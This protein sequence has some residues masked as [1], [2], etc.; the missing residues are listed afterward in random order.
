MKEIN[1]NGDYESYFSHLK[2][3][4]FIGRIYKK[5]FTSQII[6]FCAR[7]FGKSILEVGS[8]TGSGVL[9][10]FPKHVSG[11]EINPA[12]VAY[13]RSRGLRVQLIDDDG[14]F[15][16]ANG[17]VDVCIL[18]NVLEHIDDPEFTLSECHRVTANHGGLVVV[19]PGIRGYGSDQ[20][21]KKFYAE[22]DLKNLDPR[23][24]F[25]RLFSIPFFIANKNISKSLRQYCLVATYARVNERR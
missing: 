9:G 7:R 19:V 16:V 23:W 1:T 22:S 25:L 17:T 14:V 6:Y 8:G 13:C 24:E 4:S 18:D 20:D 11:L 15:P 21:H 2:G 12:S 5:Y 10:A 3:I